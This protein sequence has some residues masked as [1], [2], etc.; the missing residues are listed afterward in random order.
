MTKELFLKKLGANVSRLR[1]K[2]GI[3]QSELALRCDKDRQSIHRVEKGKINPSIFFLYQLA[4][5]L[6]VSLREI[7][8][9]D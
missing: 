2:S 3:T 9:V 4:Q 6:D 5:E 1:E 8:D 7:C